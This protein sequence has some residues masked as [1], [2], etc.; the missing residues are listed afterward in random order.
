[1]GPWG[2][3][4]PFCD[5]IRLNRFID[6]DDGKKFTGK[7]HQFDGNKLTWVSGEDFPNKTNP[8]IIT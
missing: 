6:L 7:P 4:A 2:P 1:M 3:G 5:G 8:V